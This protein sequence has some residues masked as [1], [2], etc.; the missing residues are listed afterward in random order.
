MAQE[1]TRTRSRAVSRQESGS[2]ATR[3]RP[4]Y[5]ALADIYETGDSIFV[6]AEMPG[7]APDDVDIT[8]ERSLLTIKGRAPGAEHKGYRQ[9]YAEYSDGDYERAFTLSEEIDRSR[10]KASHKN[11]L[12]VLEL[13]KA[14]IAQTKRI[15]VKAS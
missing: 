4:V 12:L 14:A 7:V 3:A 10:I 13:P 2:E 9:V 11:G 5:R 6:L 15:E 8:L 1:M